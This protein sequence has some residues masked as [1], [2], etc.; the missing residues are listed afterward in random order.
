MINQ[1]NFNPKAKVIP[2]VFIWI[3]TWYYQNHVYS[4]NGYLVILI[5]NGYNDHIYK[6]SGIWAMRILDY[7]NIYQEIILTNNNCSFL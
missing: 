6:K 1:L 3:V 2:I 4:K 7:E 5:N